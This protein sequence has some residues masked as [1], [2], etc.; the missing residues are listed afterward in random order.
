MWWFLCLIAWQDGSTIR[1]VDWIIRG[2]TVY[3][4]TLNPGR[5]VDVM[6]DGD[7]VVYLGD[8]E[9][10]HARQEID[11]S[12]LAVAPGFINML[13]WATES[14]IIDGLSQ[15]DIRQGVT[16]E[17]FGEG[18]SMGPLNETMRREMQNSQR[19]AT[20]PVAWRSLNGY[21]EWL[22]KRGV[23]PNVAS[24]VGATTVRIHV[25][26]HDNR[27]PSARELAAMQRLVRKAMEAGALGLG[28]SL[29]YAPAFF[30]NTDELVA[31]AEAIAP[32]DGIYISHLRSESARLEAAVAEL[33]EIAETAGVHGEIYHLKAAGKPHHDKLDAVIDAIA[34]ARQRGVSIGANMY[35]YTAGATGLDASMPPW[36]KSGGEKAWFQR[37]ADPKQRAKIMAEMR[38]PTSDWENLGQLAGPE[39]MLLTDF[40]NPK[41]RQYTGRTLASVAA[42]RKTSVEATILDLVIEDRSRVGT[43]YFLMSEAN[44]EKQIRLPY[45]TFG[46]DGGSLAPNPPFTH[47]NPHPRAYGNVARLLG[48]YVR[49]RQVIPLHEAVHK[50]AG[51]PATR[52]NLRHRGFLKPGFF[53][54]VVVF[55]P[56]SITDHATF[57]KPH[58]Y[59]SGVHHVWVNGTPVLAEGE[60][61]GAKPGRVVRGPGWTGWSAQK[62]AAVL[63]E[64]H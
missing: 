41:L 63:D 40:E 44:V 4:G 13:S 26:G 46:S 20:Y 12:G 1:Q 56:E 53:A 39:N 34:T 42:E 35:L 24:F 57:A 33:I 15:S 43:V 50:L 22:V 51:L 54:D 3:D 17:V 64:S 31:L 58:Q 27:T 2:G 8:G 36:T 61:T 30:A 28:S 25:M 19:D 38:D 9:G 18:W 37:L 49:D 14:L 11:A 59:A 29:I 5:K 55:D 32:Y 6:I 21:L 10:W 23:S 48:R 62:E 45:M 16:L 52:L 47:S 7:R 60:H